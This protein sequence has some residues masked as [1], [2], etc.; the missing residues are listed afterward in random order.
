MEVCG[1]V[2]GGGM[3]SEY[4]SYVG[5]GNSQVLMLPG[6]AITVNTF[7]VALFTTLGILGWKFGSRHCVLSSVLIFS[8]RI[9]TFTFP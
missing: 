5:R 7:P 9:T 6:T 4:L 3:L 1:R 2:I 8:R